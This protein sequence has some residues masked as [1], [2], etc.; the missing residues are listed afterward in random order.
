MCEHSD[1]FKAIRQQIHDGF[2]SCAD[3]LINLLDSLSGRQNAKSVVELSLEAP[4]TRQ[5]NSLYKA[6]KSAF[7]PSNE[8]AAAK[9]HQDK[10][11][12]QAKIFLPT[13]VKPSKH[14]FWL[15]AIDATPAL[16]AYAKSLPDRGITYYPNPAPGNK[17]IGVGHSYSLLALLPERDAHTPPWVVPLSCQRIA[18]KQTANQVAAAQMKALLNDSQ[19]PFGVELSVNAADSGYSKAAYLGPVGGF[20]N[21][22]EVV[23]SAKN[24]HFFHVAPNPQL[25]PGHGGRPK[26]FGATFNLKD[27]TTWGNPDEETQLDWESASGR[28]LRIKLQRWNTLLMHGKKDIP[29]HKHPFDLVLAQVFDLSGKLV[30]T[31]PMWLIVLGNRR[32]EISTQAAYE[33][34]RQRYDLEHFFRFAKNKLLLDSYQTPDLQNEENWWDLVCLAYLQL[35]LAA[36]LCAAL[37]RPWERYLPQMKEHRLLSPSQVQRD[38]GRIIRQ[39]GTPACAPKP[40]GNSPGRQK[41]TS[42]GTRAR[43]PIVF[44]GRRAPKAVASG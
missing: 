27:E 41:G 33:A 24:R 15:T 10:E 19:L 34:Y 11:L 22:V 13:C 14:P 9:E 25:H 43:Q 18:T 4:F 35:W 42:P 26:K 8:E 12:T 40:R 6:I 20:A 23:R 28:P 44:K 39:F 7:V 5:Y 31:R 21:H 16:R 29:M 32:A 30:F 17:P 37:P 38:Y 36:P 2:E 3:V 1:I